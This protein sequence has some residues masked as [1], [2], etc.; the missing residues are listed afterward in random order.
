MKKSRVKKLIFIG[1]ARPNFMKIAPI[2]RA[3]KPEKTFKS[4]IV[5]TGQHY[6]DNMSAMFF[7]DLEMPSPAYFLGTGAGSGS[8]LK[9]TAETMGRLEEIFI[10]ESP[11]L[12][13]VVGDVNSTFAAAYPAKRLGIKLAHVEAGLR[14][15]DMAMH[16]EINRMATDCLSDFFFV[17]ERSGADNLVREG[18]HKNIYFVGNV[19]IDTLYSSLDKLEKAPTTFATTG[20]KNRLGRY[21]FLT[22]HRPSNVDDRMKA[23][24]ILG[25][26]EKVSRIFPIIFPVHPRTKKMFRSFGIRFPPGIHVTGPLSYLE[27]LFL[28]KDAAAVITDSGGLQ[29]ET[30]ALGIPCFTLRNNTERP[31]TVDLGTNTL[32]KDSE[33]TSLPAM[34]SKVKRGRGTK[35]RVPKFWDGRA[36]LRIVRTLKKLAQNGSF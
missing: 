31:I 13:I 24:K 20:L 23:E 1:G 21:I 14:S 5:H 25:E 16:E 4:L 7:K 18:K 9:K 12:V 10:K 19:M 11:D 3:L 29:E 33:I 32:V 2:V 35:G 22:L 15:R 17:T 8:P 30:T 26:L 27:S 6:D 28:W 36:A 34:I